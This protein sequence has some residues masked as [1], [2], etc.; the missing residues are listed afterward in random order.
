MK[1]LRKLIEAF[2]ALVNALIVLMA[3]TYLTNL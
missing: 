1:N 3:M 2:V